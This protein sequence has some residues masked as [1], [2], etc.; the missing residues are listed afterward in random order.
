M[1]QPTY[2]YS[3]VCYTATSG[4]T[5]FALTS[6]DGNP[7]GYLSPSHIHVRTSADSGETWN[8]LPADTGWTFAD[9]ATSIVLTTPATVGEWV[10]IQRKTPI[11]ED[12]VDFQ[13][14]SLLTAGQL[15]DA[16][17]FSLYCDQEIAD[18][19]SGLTPSIIGLDTT[20]DLPEGQINLYYTDARVS[21]WI[22]ANLSDTDDL[23]EGVLNLYY[24]DA[25]VNAW[26]NT[27]LSNT[28][29]LAEGSNNLYYT[30]AR[31]EAVV[32]SWI[33]ANLSDTDDLPEGST[34]LYYK[35]S[36]VAAWI[37][38]NLSST[39]Q[40]VEGSTN[41]YYTDA[42][43]ES[44]VDGQ[45]YVKGPVVTKIVAGNNVGITPESGTGI[46]TINATGGS[47]AGIPEAP[48]DGTAYGRQDGHWEP[49][50]MLTGGDL[51][52]D[53]TLGTDKIVLGI[54]GSVVAA[55][56]TGDGSGLTNLNVDTYW[57]ED[58]STSAIKNLD[59]ITKVS[60]NG[61][62]H[63]DANIDI[64]SGNFAIRLFPSSDNT[65]SYTHI[66]AN[67][68]Y[69]T[70]SVGQASTG[71]SNPWTS[72]VQFMVDATGKTIVGNDNPNGP[73][74]AAAGAQLTVKGDSSFTGSASFSGEL[75]AGTRLRLN[76]NGTRSNAQSVVDIYDQD[77][78]GVNASTI[79]LNAGG[80]ASFA[81][82]LVEI[83]SSQIYIK[84]DASGSAYCQLGRLGILETLR[85]GTET[86]APNDI[87]YRARYKNGE[88]ISDV[89]SFK[90]DGSASFAGTVTAKGVNAT[91]VFRAEQTN[92]SET[93]I[94]LKADG[95][96]SFAGTVEG[97]TRTNGNVTSF[98]A[99]CNSTTI[100][101]APIRILNG[102]NSG[103]SY[104]ISGLGQSA[105]QV[106]NVKNDGSATFAGNLTTQSSIFATGGVDS[107]AVSTGS[108]GQAGVKLVNDGSVIIQR[109]A[110]GT[111]FEVY[112]GTSKTISFDSNGGILAAG[113]SMASLAQL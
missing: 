64:N 47:G 33:Q 90:Y 50:L 7:I 84:S 49:V 74:V 82:N 20:D 12:W 76:T 112:N 98:F 80:S 81:N 71:V 31:A 42:R 23:K 35:D 94:E 59:S 24:T 19:V 45:G 105:A 60:F 56:F 77:G 37:N 57:E 6:T 106:F 91:T 66:G 62:V 88:N 14:G 72:L 87:A 10:D 26:I 101:N 104:L 2:E 25:R 93:K 73:P 41:L 5:V 38:R 110:G 27:N 16:E 18:S 95:S 92:A 111:C 89:I 53:L 29:Q 65:G 63:T 78:Q 39:D 75:L 32:V 97:D 55:S 52:G 79:R 21:A 40:L 103:S 67:N 96:A 68:N 8:I 4:Q 109:S 46:V 11:D 69:G 36:R 83:D 102:S 54:D 13:A 43:V 44:Y 1:V 30:D 100:D 85:S 99:N 3:G 17:T 61:N 48:L 113:Y 22:A 15:N 9:P 70:L 58:G 28:D 107:G 51:T 34:N 86:S 108:A